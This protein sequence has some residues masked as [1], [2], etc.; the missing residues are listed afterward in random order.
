[1]LTQGIMNGDRCSRFCFAF[2]IVVFGV[3]SSSPITRRDKKLLGMI[4]PAQEANPR[5]L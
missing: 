4:A 2:A 5:V 3:A 1:M